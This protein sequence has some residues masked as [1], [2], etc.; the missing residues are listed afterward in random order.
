[1]KLQ[2]QTYWQNE[3]DDAVN[4]GWYSDFYGEMYGPRGPRPDGR[5]DGCY[6]NY[7]DAD[8]VDWQTL[9]YKDNYPR[10]QEAKARWDPLDVFN[11]KQSIELP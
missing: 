11:H 6:V 10:L 4:L 1:M 7:P 8:L 9:Y 2:Y 5:L 3:T